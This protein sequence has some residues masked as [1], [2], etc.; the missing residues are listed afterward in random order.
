MTHGFS[1]AAR[2]VD[3]QASLLIS[4]RKSRVDVSG[5]VTPKVTLRSLLRVSAGQKVTP[6]LTVT[7]APGSQ[8]SH[9]FPRLYKTGKRD[10]SD[11]QDHNL[12]ARTDIWRPL[13]RRRSDAVHNASGGFR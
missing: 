13:P 6:D 5:K 9:V 8:K 3:Y 1:H 10:F 4:R 11:P 2:F 12:K 7:H